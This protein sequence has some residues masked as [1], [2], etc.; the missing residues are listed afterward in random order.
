MTTSPLQEVLDEP[1]RRG[2]AAVILFG[3]I[4]VREL[5]S[6]TRA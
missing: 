2:L 6:P 3:V 4:D 1:V 5:C